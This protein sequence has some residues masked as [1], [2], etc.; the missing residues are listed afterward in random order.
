MLENIQ[1]IESRE[2]VDE[3]EP[4]DSCDAV[5]VSVL[6]HAISHYYSKQ[7]LVIWRMHSLTQTFKI[8]YHLLGI[9]DDCID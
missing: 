8:F 4:G 6:V 9:I 7:S 5:R 2:R 3:N 1:V